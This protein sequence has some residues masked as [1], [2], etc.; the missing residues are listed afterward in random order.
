MVWIYLYVNFLIQILLKTLNR[1]SNKLWFL[2]QEARSS[3]ASFSFFIGGNHMDRKAYII[4]LYNILCEKSDPD[5]P[6]SESQIRHYL[7]TD[8]SWVSLQIYRKY[9]WHPNRWIWKRYQIHT[10]QKR[11]RA[12][13]DDSVRQLLRT[14]HFLT[15]I[16]R[17]HV[18]DFPK[19]TGCRCHPETEWYSSSPEK[20][21]RLINTIYSA[22]TDRPEASS[23]NIIHI[24][25]TLCVRIQEDK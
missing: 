17:Y 5:H 1:R 16:Y 21:S 11:S 4:A 2:S 24:N 23:I 20:Y 25:R 6:L 15:E 10:A 3:R 22:K 12:F 7:E 8:Q 13:Q 18:P 19:K 14:C 9:F